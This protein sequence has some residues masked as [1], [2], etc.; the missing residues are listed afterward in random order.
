M[1]SLAAGCSSTKS[2]ARPPP[3][4]QVMTGA[5]CLDKLHALSVRQISFPPKGECAIDTPVRVEGLGIAFSPAAT[6]GCG[7]AERLHE[8]DEAVIQPS[9]K[10]HFHSSAV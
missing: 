10:R 8:F 5:V 3:P 1:A 9:A 7:L 2:S 4:S 6:M